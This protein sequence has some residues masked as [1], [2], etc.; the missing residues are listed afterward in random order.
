MDGLDIRLDGWGD[1]RHADVFR[2]LFNEELGAIVQVPV[3]ERAAFADLVAQ[4]GLIECAQRIARPTTAAIIR[5]ND[6]DEVL[7]EWRWEELFDAWWSVTHAMQK[8]RDNPDGAEAYRIC[9]GL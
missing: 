5:V 2:T 9:A 1:G 6:E 8:L 4:H 7:A 3:E